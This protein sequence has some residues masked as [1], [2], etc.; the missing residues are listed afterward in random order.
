MEACRGLGHFG[1]DCK[2]LNRLYINGL[3]AKVVTWKAARGRRL[4]VVGFMVSKYF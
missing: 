4:C 1:V 3:E 2:G